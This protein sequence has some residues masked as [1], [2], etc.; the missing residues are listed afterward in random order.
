MQRDYMFLNINTMPFIY[1]SGIDGL[2]KSYQ[3]T[4]LAASHFILAFLQVPQFY[5]QFIRE[6][7]NDLDQ[8]LIFQ[9]KANNKTLNLT[10]LGDNIIID[11]EQESD[12]FKV[13]W[14]TSYTYAKLISYTRK[15]NGKIITQRLDSSILYVD[16]IL[17]NKKYSLIIPYNINYY[18][19]NQQFDSINEHTTI[20]DLKRLYS[21]LFLAYQTD[22]EKSLFST[23][24]IFI[25]KDNGSELL[26]DKLYLKE[27]YTEKYFL[28]SLKG[29]VQV[30]I[31][32]Y[33]NLPGK[34]TITN[35]QKQHDLNLSETIEKIY[36]RSRMI[37]F[38]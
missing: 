30:S 20:I 24:S 10:I 27:G 7:S 21:D 2:I 17:S 28:S 5:L 15:Q 19:S 4:L 11:Y 37:N 31:E 23:L 13:S 32:G 8:K 1:D 34:I 3:T 35:Y 14:D 26:L 12:V 9:A 25:R 38:N 33:P 6:E 36:Q 18:L 22:Y 16:I 29:D